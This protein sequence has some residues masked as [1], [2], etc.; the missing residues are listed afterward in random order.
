MK[1]TDAIKTFF[2]TPDKPVSSKEIMAFARGDKAG[3]QDLV[4]ET[5]AY[6]EANGEPSVAAE[7]VA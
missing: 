5:L 7:K 1:G 4:K 3:Y 2:S 6:F